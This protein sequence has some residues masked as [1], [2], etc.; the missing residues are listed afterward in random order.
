MSTVK[1]IGISLVLLIILAIAVVYFLFQ[2][3]MK[4]VD[5]S[6]SSDVF[7]V[8]QGSSITSTLQKL[9]EE[10]LIRSAFFTRLYLRFTDYDGLQAGHYELSASMDTKS[11]LEKIFSGSTIN[12]NEI[13]VTFPE[14]KTLD[15]FAEILSNSTDYS[16]DD[17]V[18]VWTD[19]AFILEAIENYWFISDEIQNPNLK[20]ALNGYFF[21]NTYKFEDPQVSPETVGK[22]LLDQMDQVL[23]KYKDSIESSKYSPH[24]IL[25]LASIIEY[26]AI[27]DE[28]RPMISG[29]FH[30]RLN[31]SMRLQSCATLQMALGV[32][33]EIYTNQDMQVDSPYN[34]YRVDGLPIGPGNSPGEKSIAAAL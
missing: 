19:D 12:P 9:E 34:T 30:N 25:T 33:K 21:P 5:P 31:T 3:A 10:S 18:S 14:G 20:Y 6:A 29:V 7:L 16:R 23:S 24:E 2:N 32:H 1:K 13:T 26:E 11:M 15:E 4:P 22:R 28:D 27:E 8:E 17:I